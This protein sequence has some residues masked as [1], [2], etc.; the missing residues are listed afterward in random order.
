MYLILWNKSNRV[1]YNCLPSS[2]GHN[3][4]IHYFC[5]FYPLYFYLSTKKSRYMCI[6]ILLIIV[7]F[8]GTSLVDPHCPTS[9]A[10]K[11]VSWCFQSMSHFFQTWQAVK[12]SRHNIFFNEMILSYWQIPRW[13]RLN[14]LKNYL[15]IKAGVIKIFLWV[16]K[17]FFI[18]N[19]SANC[20]LGDKSYFEYSGLL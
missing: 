10:L 19:L 4:C 7:N 1:Q 13:Y 8:S 16:R 9:P 15:Q 3:H 5:L 17:C 12:Q 2:C 18:D 14:N 11:R 20:N 6:C